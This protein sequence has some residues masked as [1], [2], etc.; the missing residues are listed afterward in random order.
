MSWGSVSIFMLSVVCAGATAWVFA[1]KSNDRPIHAGIFVCKGT[2][3]TN[4]N[5]EVFR[6][7]RN[8]CCISNVNGMVPQS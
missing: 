4:L 7:S 8:F 3:S 1:Y 2:L 5:C 6:K